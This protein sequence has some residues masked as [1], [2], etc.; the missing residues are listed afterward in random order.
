MRNNTVQLPLFESKEGVPSGSQ[1][2]QLYEDDHEVVE[3]FKWVA[4]HCKQNRYLCVWVL[5]EKL[6]P[7]VVGIEISGNHMI[8]I[9]S[10]EYSVAKGSKSLASIEVIFENKLSVMDCSNFAGLCILS[11]IPFIDDGPLTVTETLS[12][13]FMERKRLENVWLITQHDISEATPFDIVDLSVQY[14]GILTWR[15][16]NWRWTDNH[17]HRQLK[18]ELEDSKTFYLTLFDDF[19]A[20]IWRSGTDML[21]NYFNKNWLRFTGR[22]LEEEM[23]NGWTEGVHP[24]DYDRCL[25][26]YV[27]NFKLRQPF[28]ME[29]R[30]RHHGGEYRWILDMG[31]PFKDLYGEFAGYIGSCY[32]ITERI[33]MEKQ[34]QGSVEEEQQT[35]TAKSNFLSQMSH[36]IRTPMNGVIGMLD[37]LSMS[38]LNEE[39]VECVELARTSAKRL[40]RII[41][42]ILDYSRIEAGY[43]EL[44]YYPFDLHMLIKSVIESLHV[45]KKDNVELRMQI[46]PE[47]PAKLVGDQIRISQILI[48]L[49]SNAMKFTEQGEVTLSVEMES[50]TE[51]MLTLRCSVKDTGI[52]I[53]EDQQE[54]IFNRF[55]QVDNIG[56][57]R[58]SGSGLGLTISKLLV[59]RMGGTIYAESKE[60]E[61][62]LFTFTIVLEKTAS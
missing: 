55:A 27:A 4:N 11:G 7:E 23:G 56:K 13:L 46:A 41:N 3:L 48:N 5:P 31:M 60:G 49:V 28:S 6:T 21:C 8:V 42:D 16:G 18:Q 36:E 58:W 54:K 45:N 10:M 57:L 24:E 52:G 17:A 32:D 53:P 9:S 25:S 19:P 40:V 62:S 30:L 26:H 50:E 44:E 47:V 51:K 1:I 34:L 43:I 12:R 35:N 39:Q 14:D 29:Y 38:T 33:N 61:G 15:Q 2:C 59:Q 37:I 20:L 22:T